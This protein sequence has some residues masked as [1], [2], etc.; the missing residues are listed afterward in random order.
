MHGQRVSAGLHLD[1]H[2]LLRLTYR[3]GIQVLFV[4]MDVQSDCLWWVPVFPYAFF[5]GSGFDIGKPVQPSLFIGEQIRRLGA[6][7]SVL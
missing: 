4:Q 7:I 2:S 5:Q 1:V 3:F 6:H